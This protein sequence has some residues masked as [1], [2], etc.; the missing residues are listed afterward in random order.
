MHDALTGLCNR[1]DF[2]EQIG[3]QISAAQRNGQAFSLVMVDVDH[4]K[5]YNDAF[6]HLKGD[7][8]LAAVADALAGVVR[9]PADFIAR[10]G[11]EAFVVVLPETDAREAEAFAERAREVALRLRI[12]ATTPSRYVTVSAGCATSVPSKGAPSI[13]TRLVETADAALHRAKAAGRTHI[14]HVTHDN[15]SSTAGR[16][17]RL[18]LLSSLFLLYIK[19]VVVDNGGWFLWIA[20]ENAFASTVCGMHNPSDSMCR[21]VDDSCR[22]RLTLP[23]DAEVIPKLWTT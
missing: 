8:C 3:T 6:G 13:D 21:C 16:P 1:S 17:S 22:A 23:A 11:G 10:Y 20:A 9:H 15:R 5:R 7:A 4:F 19:I 14:T 2:N 18:S 12:E